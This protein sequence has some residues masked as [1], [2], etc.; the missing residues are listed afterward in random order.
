[1]GGV[2]LSAAKDLRAADERSFATLRMTG[3]I[4]AFQKN[5]PVKGGGSAPALVG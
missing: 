4:G 1:V 3:K 5:L 2:I